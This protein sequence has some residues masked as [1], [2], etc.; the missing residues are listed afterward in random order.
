MIYIIR[1]LSV[2]SEQIRKRNE[3]LQEGVANAEKLQN[4]LREIEGSR[5]ERLLNV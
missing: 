4:R 1:P 3:R 5:A 2:T